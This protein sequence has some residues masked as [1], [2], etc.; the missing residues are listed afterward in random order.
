MRDTLFHQSP[1]WLGISGL[2]IILLAFRTVWLRVSNSKTRS[3]ISVPAPRKELQSEFS[4]D[5][6]DQI[7]PLEEFDLDNE[8]P[9]KIR[10]FKDKYYL[11]MGIENIAANDLIVMD[12]TYLARINL[13]K[14]LINTH[15]SDVLAYNPIITPAVTEYYT[16]LLT[17]Y[18]PRRFPTIYTLHPTTLFNTTTNTHIPLTPPSTAAALRILGENIDTD[19]L[20]LLPTPLPP[21]SGKEGS[22][23]TLQGFITCFPSGF[24]T[25]SK[26]NLSLAD[27]HAPVPG[28]AEKLERSMDKF[29]AALPA[30]RIV[31]RCNWG[32]TTD[33]RLFAM[34]GNHMSEDELRDRRTH[35]GKEEEEEEEEVFDVKDCVL[36]IE[37]QT[38]HRLPRTGAVVFAFK[39]YQYPLG[40]IVDEGNGEALAKA[41]E[42]LGEG[43]VP[44]MKVYKREVVWGER[45]KRFLRGEAGGE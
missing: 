40:D 21:S 37:R 27:I 28:Y 10:P 30:G 17:I 39:T 5:S 9:L 6:Y 23:Y 34:S 13:R 43:N 38:L 1:L 14:H 20:F 15:T 2:L 4:V 22:K 19:F 18:L 44:G 3:S 25:L 24:A 36:R 8:E 33:D 45:V 31:R 32:V 26:L 7:D 42:G 41:I 12:K 16:Y 29:F 11:T 35:N